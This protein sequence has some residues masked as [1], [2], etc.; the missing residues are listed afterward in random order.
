MS[1]N[2]TPD[3]SIERNRPGKS[4]GVKNAPARICQCFFVCAFSN[5][6]T[7]ASNQAARGR[8]GHAHAIFP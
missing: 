8:G 2:L 6:V 7:C 3:A 5:V 4:A 1:A